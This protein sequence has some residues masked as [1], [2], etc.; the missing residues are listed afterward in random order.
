IQ[1]AYFVDRGNREYKGNWNRIQNTARVYT[2]DDKAIQTPNSDTPYSTIGAD[3]RAEPLILTFPAVEK[4]RY[5]CA[6]FIDAY[7]FNFAYVGSRAT[8]NDGG[9]FL[10]AGPDWNG[11]TPQGI[12]SVIRSETQFAFVLYR[13][14]LFKAGDIGKVEKI[15]AGYA[16]Q[17]LSQYLGKPA[18]E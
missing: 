17:T 5:F 10:L 7:T 12:R 3:L 14:Q 15:Q 16:V 1:Y 2:P 13:T 18:P 8:G 4:G 9:S 6:Q 11:E